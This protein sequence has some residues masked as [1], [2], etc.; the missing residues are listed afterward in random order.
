MLISNN[1]FKTSTEFLFQIGPKSL[2]FGG[3]GW[4]NNSSYIIQVMIPITGIVNLVT[5]NV[6]PIAGYGAQ[7][8]YGG[9]MNYV[10]YGGI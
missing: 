3:W 4:L 2:L 5:D 8:Y 9:Q 1:F 10:Q 6:F 7:P